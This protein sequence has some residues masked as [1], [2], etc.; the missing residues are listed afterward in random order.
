MDEQIVGSLNSQQREIAH[1]LHENSIQLQ[2]LIEDLLDFSILQSH[3]SRTL[4][5][6]VELDALIEEVLE[7]HKVALLSRQLELS[8]SLEAVSLVGDREKLRT[9]VDN[10]VSNAVKYS[11][12]GSRLS[13]SLSTRDSQAVIEVADSGPGIPWAERERVFEA[14][15]Q[16]E[17]AARGHVRGSGLGLS[18][19]REHAQAHGGDISV[20]ECEASGA[21]LRVVLPLEQVT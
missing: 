17:P 4:H 20:V 9:L 15:F 21:C 14:F 8:K 19:A 2:K 16:G 5:A 3:Q 12:L 13:V 11:P 7:D 10:L 18:I 6:G 1:I